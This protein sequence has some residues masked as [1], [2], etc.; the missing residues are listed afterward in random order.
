MSLI[1]IILRWDF[2]IWELIFIYCGLFF[3][4]LG[5][6]CVV[7]SFT[8]FR[9]NFTSGLL[10]VIL[11]RPRIGMLSLVTVSPVITAFHSCC[12]SLHVF[13]QVNLW[14]AWI[15]FETA[16]F[17]QCSPGTAETQRLY[18]LRIWSL[19]LFGGKLKKI[20]AVPAKIRTWLIDLSCNAHVQFPIRC[21]MY[22]SNIDAFLFSDDLVLYS[23]YY[24]YDT[25]IN[26]YSSLQWVFIFTYVTLCFV[27]FFIYF[28]FSF[29]F[30]ISFISFILICFSLLWFWGFFVLFF[31]GFFFFLF[32]FFFCVFL[33]CF[34]AAN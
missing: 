31:V 4:H 1:G 27:L 24:S 12:L 30:I 8:T 20:L 26:Y 28:Y 23:N 10:Q 7:S 11:P 32:W 16:I 9:P 33:F 14:P 13:D 19:F 2:L 22:K 5:N 25:E 15:G 18:P 21:N 29:Y 17:W 3:P 34:F 6:F